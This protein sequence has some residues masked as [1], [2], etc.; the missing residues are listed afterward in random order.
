[1][2]GCNGWMDDDKKGQ[3]TALSVKNKANSS[4]RKKEMRKDN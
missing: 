1:M 2:E 3:W 4:E